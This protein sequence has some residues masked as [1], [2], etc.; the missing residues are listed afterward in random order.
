MAGRRESYEACGEDINV[1][2]VEE[3]LKEV[4]DALFRTNY[5]GSTY[6]KRVGEYV[7]NKQIREVI[8]RTAGLLSKYTEVD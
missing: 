7:F 8:I 3:K 5:E 2:T 6:Q 1:V 4:Y